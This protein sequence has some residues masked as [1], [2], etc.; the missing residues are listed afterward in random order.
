MTLSK[1]IIFV[2]LFFICI[3]AGCEKENKP[4]K[5]ISKMNIS[6]TLIANVVKN[7]MPLFAPAKIGILDEKHLIIYDKQ[8]DKLFK[9]YNL[10]DIEYEFE[11]G[12]IGRG[13]GELRNGEVGSNS[14]IIDSSR[15]EFYN[16]DTG[17]LKYFEITDKGFSYTST[18]RLEYDYQL[19]PLYRL[20]KFTD[21]L[22]IGDVGWV[23]VGEELEPK[24]KYIALEPDNSNDLFR[25]GKYPDTELKNYDRYNRYK[26]VLAKKPS[27]EK[28]VAF[29]EHIDEGKIYDLNG[30]LLINMQMTKNIDDE[31]KFRIDIQSTNKNIYAHYLN[32]AESTIFDE[33]LDYNP[34]I[35][36]WNWEGDLVDKV[37]LDKP[38]H[39]FTVSEKYNKLYGISLLV[40]DQIY[41][42]DLSSIKQN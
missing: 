29:N 31:N 1:Q 19:R 26:T 36:V 16:L 11:W 25:F 8:G 4:V 41:E 6:D 22:Y 34:T 33:G 30:N 32:A 13:P 20:I 28:F 14:I 38:I 40:S 24:H 7:D 10:P 18:R 37:V 35:E 15:V 9:L 5:K 39:Y 21:N 27:G 17:E 3:I 23:N 2:I 12:V 42:Y